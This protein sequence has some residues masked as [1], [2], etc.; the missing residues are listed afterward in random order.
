MSQFVLFLFSRNSSAV[1]YLLMDT[2]MT[3]NHLKLTTKSGQIFNTL[4]KLKNLRNWWEFFQITESNCFISC[5]SCCEGGYPFKAVVV[6]YWSFRVQF[7]INNALIIQTWIY[8][9]QTPFVLFQSD[10]LVLWKI[11][12]QK[13]EVQILP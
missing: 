12:T 13:V 9:F 7:L 1:A 11:P 8:K 6:I 5:I 4:A 10:Q 3:L 2:G